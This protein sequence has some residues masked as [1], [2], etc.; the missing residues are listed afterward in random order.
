MAHARNILCWWMERRPRRACRWTCR[1]WTAISTPLSGHKLYGPTG[2]GVLYGK[3]E[4]L[5]AMPPFQVAVT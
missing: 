1:N 4:L 3:A 2:I 5:E